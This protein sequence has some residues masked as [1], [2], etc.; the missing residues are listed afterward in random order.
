MENS[1]SRGAAQQGN[2]CDIVCYEF[3]TIGGGTPTRIFSFMTLLAHPFSASGL[4]CLVFVL[5]TPILAENW[6]LWRGPAG[7]GVSGETGLPVRWSTTENV[8]WRTPLPERGNST[9]IV[10]RDRI[11]VTQ[12][13]EKNGKR[14]LMCLD[15]TTG[16][17]LW[18][19]GVA[20]LEKESTHATN[21]H[22][23]PSPVTD[24]ERVIAWFGSAGLVCYDF[25]GKVLWRRDLGK[26]AHIWGYGSSP[27]LHGDLCI[28]NFGPGERSFLIAVNKR[29]GKT[30]W[31]VDEPGGNFGNNPSEWTGSWSTPLVI[32]TGGREELIV[33][34]PSRAAAFDLRTG[35]ELWTC[36]GLNPLVY[37]SPLWAEG[38]LVLMGGFNGSSLAVRPGG[39]GDVTGTHRLWQ[40]PKTKQRIGSGVIARGH[41]YIL[42]E[43]GVAGCYELQ[44][45]NMVWQE[46]LAGPSKELTS[47]SSMVLADGK[48]YVI[49][50]G[51]DTFVLKPSP[52]FELISANPL[53]ETTNAS[54]A[55]SN[56]DIF[57][58]THQALWCIWK[59]E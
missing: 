31:Q 38:V 21:P 50:Q 9:P 16:K 26:Q 12:A 15:R 2:S 25:Q 32:Q 5:C 36:R 17:L 3:D 20:Y 42:D 45:G 11:F 33:G 23:S 13:L 57:I 19:S 6:P 37:T 48:L 55:I 14:R 24:G 59:P 34:L 22:C 44:T 40:I 18:Q 43:P 39:S 35:K 1:I 53:G 29:S 51:G 58:R 10:W 56:G 47:W 7:T 4:L 46:R 27:I 54:L 30:L 8:R 49:N 28:L 52:K 41:I